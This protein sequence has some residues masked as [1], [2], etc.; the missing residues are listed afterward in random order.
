[1]CSDEIFIVRLMGSSCG[2]FSCDNICNVTDIFQKETTNSVSA[3][4]L[5]ENV[6]SI[7]KSAKEGRSVNLF[8]ISQKIK[9]KNTR[10]GVLNKWPKSMLWGHTLGVRGWFCRPERP[11]KAGEMGCQE[12]AEVHRGEVQSPTRG[13]DQPQA[14]GGTGGTEMTSSSSPWVS[15]VPWCVSALRC[16]AAVLMKWLCPKSAVF[17]R[18]L[19]VP[20]TGRSR[21]SWQLRTFWAGWSHK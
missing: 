20:V 17:S 21:I 10:S 19:A 15:A 13:E 14:P 8:C 3:K 2:P 11:W 5:A 4:R 6:S 16:M 12:P 9:R 18:D 7:Q 1:M